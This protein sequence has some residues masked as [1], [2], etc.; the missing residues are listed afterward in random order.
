MNDKLDKNIVSSFPLLYRDRYGSIY[1]SSMPWGFPFDEKNLGWFDLVWELSSKLE[2]LIQKWIDENNPTDCANCGCDEK[3]HIISCMNLHYLPYTFQWKWKPLGW[4]S[5]A[6]NWNDRWKIV[7]NKYFRH[8][9]LERIKSRISRSINFV[10]KLLHENYGV[11]KVL[12]CWCKKYL[13]RH[14]CAS[15]CKSK[16]GTLRFYLT[17]GTDEMFALVDEYEDRSAT[18]CE[19]CGA[20]GKLRDDRYWLETLC[21]VCELKAAKRFSEIENKED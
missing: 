13:Q 11:T 17:S 9:F 8:Y 18:V 14:P 12:P 10:L 3:V 16:Y 2:P 7:K 4:P 1:S 20:V 21:D 19:N 6:Q 15:Q 5:K